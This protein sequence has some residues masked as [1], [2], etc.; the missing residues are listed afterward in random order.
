MKLWTPP[1]TLPLS[2]YHHLETKPESE[3]TAGVNIYTTEGFA[4]LLFITLLFTII[5]QQMFSEQLR[6][7]LL[8]LRP[9]SCLWALVSAEAYLPVQGAS[10]GPALSLQLQ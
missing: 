8:Q 6:C 1:E 3:Q 9:T 2:L 4:A 7:G 10:G 5:M